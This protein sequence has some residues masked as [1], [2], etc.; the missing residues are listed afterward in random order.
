MKLYDDYRRYA[1]GVLFLC[2]P[3]LAG[4]QGLG[5]LLHQVEQQ[6]P[7]LRG[8]DA[9]A[10]A[11]RSGVSIA[12]SQ[13]WGHAELFGKSTH[14]NQDRLVN[15]LAYPPV[16]KRNLFDKNSYLYGASFTLPVDVNGVIGSRVRVQKHQ[17]SAAQQRIAQTRLALFSQTVNLY[18]GLQ[19][20]AGVKKALN[21]QR[22]ALQK[23]QKITQTAVRVGR[24]AKVELYR[25]E[26]EIK[27]VEGQLAGLRGN[28]S[29]LRANLAALLNKPVFDDAVTILTELPPDTASAYPSDS[30][31]SNR[32][33]LQAASSIQDAE[34][35]GVKGA[36]REWLP[37]FSLQAETLHNQGFTAPALNSWSISGQLAWQFWDGGRRSAHT[38]QAQAKQAIAKATYQ[39]TLNRAQAEV[40]A[41][42]A[43]FKAAALQYAATTAGLKASRETERIQSDRFASGRISAVDLIDSEAALARSKADHTS[44]LAHWWLADDQLHLAHGDLPTAYTTKDQ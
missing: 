31:L 29:R 21:E 8:A 11:A 23:H 43:D 20:L 7:Q 38:D 5:E 27:S 35:E 37:S 44:A 14:Y 16:L 2:F 30:T 9:Q 13:Y 1:L 18:R 22:K 28:E 25:I 40:Q 4:A 24:V 19:Q 34:A 42:Q 26:A 36:K 17:Q 12:K 10:E 15:P 41:A 6:S 3:Y 32:P 33:D 39:D